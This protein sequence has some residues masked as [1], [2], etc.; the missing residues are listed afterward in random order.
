MFK[1]S[2]LYCAILSTITVGAGSAFTQAAVIDE[3]IVTATKRAESMQEVPIAITAL[4]G[5]KLDAIG[6]FQDY[7]QLLP[8]V[9]FQGTGPGQNEIFIRGAATSQTVVTLS[10]AAGLQPS[11]ALYLDEMPVAVAGRNLDVYTTDMERVEVLPGP[12]GTLFGA[13]SQ[14][15][16]VRLIT[17][18][19]NH[20]EFSAGFD[21]SA[22][23]TKGG[24]MSNAVE[25]YINLPLTDK[26]A[27]RVATYNDRQGGWIDNIA[28]NPSQG[29]YNGSATV[30]SRVSGGV[31]SDAA[32]TPVSVPQNNRLVE[33]DFNDAVYAG[34][35][36]G[37][38][39]LINEDWDLLLQ[40]TA[41]SL[42]TEGV[43]SYDPTLD[44]ESST[45]RFNND[46]N[47][48]D[49]GLT[50]WTLKGR[51][52][53]LE[54]VYTGGYLDREVNA[55]IDYTGYT[56]GGLFAAYYVCSYG[57]AVN[58][59]DEA[60]LDPTKFYIEETTN[61][62]ET[63]EIRFNTSP[64]N[65][66]RVTAGI[67]LDEQ[68]LATVGQ[69]QLLSLDKISSPLNYSLANPSAA[70]I[71]TPNG[72]PF[73]AEVSFVNDVTRTTEQIAVFA[74]F[75][76]DLSDNITASLGARWYEIEDTYK[77]STTTVDITGR[78]A[79]FGD[80][81]LEA[82]TGFFGDTEG[83]A[84]F[85]A[86]E[87][88]QLDL[89]GLDSSG[90]LTVDDIILKASIDWQASDE[91]LI[92]STYSQGFRPPATNRVG[93]SLASASTPGN[94]FE[95]FRIPI[96][97]TTDDLDNYE[98][99]IKSDLLEGSLR[100]NATAFYSEITDLQTSRFDPT[101]ISFL[102]FIDN[103][104]DAEILGL[105]ADF[106]WRPTETLTLSGAFSLL[107]TEITRLN[108]DLQGVAPPIGS[109]L[110]YSADFSASLSARYDF[111]LE[112][113]GGLEAYVS[114]TVTYKG[115]SLAGMSMDA[116]LAE[117]TTELVYG[118]GSGLK[119]E[120][121]ADNFAG[122]SYTDSNGNTV[123]GGRYIQEGY[124]MLNLAFG[125]NRDGWGA[126]LFV[127]NVADESATLYID[128]QNFTPKVVT[129]R[130]RTIGLRFSYDFE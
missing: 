93:G 106:T 99:G 34:V 32:N 25:A 13:S 88:G 97:S 95:G 6:N 75:E 28:N 87:N 12:Q 105:D 22:E 77:G 96:A 69:F 65:A 128:T 43:W 5:E 1:K 117:D 3:V 103:V 118:R 78:L 115:D 33:D 42:D 4:T 66:W 30:I 54:I 127:D 86:I 37:A 116:F 64:D 23:S 68:E 84:L 16:T 74:N 129:S 101:N 76:F 27:V 90:S 60:C 89:T 70:G 114:G 107:D 83:T 47:E 102:W 112:L 73:G 17:N 55:A 26:L 119:I 46:E 44:G 111:E 71:N 41:Q 10:S 123:A 104:G 92:F 8:N 57:G 36:F 52:D 91:I 100:F 50:T 19:P 40:H 15:G 35:R 110:P 94:N 21:I 20:D 51:L 38:S 125:V 122:A 61:T 81:S 7:V 9:T 63:H 56:N 98:I 11:V 126:E 113:A 48:D 29:G 49:F 14:A 130:P 121:E 53:E 58:P 59:A 24:E 31:L 85:S 120:H 67:F 79:A 2:K 80:G 62:R 39:F 18:K 72:G 124:S 109:K 45:V 82:L 108:S